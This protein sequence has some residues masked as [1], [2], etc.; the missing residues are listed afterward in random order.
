ME[1]GISTLEIVKE[2][3][4]E[5]RIM[6]KENRDMRE[7]QIEMHNT[8]LSILEQAEK[9]NGRV[10]KSEDRITLL[11]TFKT[12]AMFLWSFVIAGVTF[13]VNKFF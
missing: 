10:S 8:L 3:R 9:T 12:R 11:E 1:D 5:H 13:L 4:D 7:R 6:F 2:M